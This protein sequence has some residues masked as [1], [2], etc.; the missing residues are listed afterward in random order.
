[1]EYN[2]LKCNLW[3]RNYDTL[4]N[5]VHCSF[6]FIAMFVIVA[7]HLPIGPGFICIFFSATF[8]YSFCQ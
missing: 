1:M 7:K 2:Y 8:D 4:Y 3:S 5:Y 6:V